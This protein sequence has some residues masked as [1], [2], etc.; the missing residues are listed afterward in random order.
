M[1]RRRTK[2]QMLT[3]NIIIIF[4]WQKCLLLSRVTSRWHIVLSLFSHAKCNKSLYEFKYWTKRK[5]NVNRKEKPAVHCAKRENTREHLFRSKDRKT[6]TVV[7]KRRLWKRGQ[8]NSSIDRYQAVKM[9]CPLWKR[10]HRFLFHFPS[11]IALS[12]ISFLLS[13]FIFAHGNHLFLWTRKHT[14]PRPAAKRMQ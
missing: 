12:P 11:H 2:A 6:T 14:L 10:S 9:C 7:A 1:E 3:K 5:E 13:L 8:K 4:G